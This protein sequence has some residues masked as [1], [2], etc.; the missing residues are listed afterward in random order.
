[1][2]QENKNPNM[3]AARSEQMYKAEQHIVAHLK[4]E[5]KRGYLNVEHKFYKILK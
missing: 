1:M 4:E 2:D 5:C 3:A